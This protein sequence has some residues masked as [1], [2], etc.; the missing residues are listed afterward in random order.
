MCSEDAAVHS[1]KSFF[2]W[3]SWDL[4]SVILCNVKINRKYTRD[5]RQRIKI[6]PVNE[7]LDKCFGP[8]MRR[9]FLLEITFEKVELVLYSGTKQLR[10]PKI[11]C[12]F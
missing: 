7:T 5:K 8:N 2:S 10:N 1:G 11:R 6:K 9:Y 12:S 4:C 3:V